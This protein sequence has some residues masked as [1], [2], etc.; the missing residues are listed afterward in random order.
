MTT[1]AKKLR[2]NPFGK[3]PPEMTASLHCFCTNEQTYGNSKL[4]DNREN[5]DEVVLPAVVE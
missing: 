3:A 1:T 2:I 5:V 4:N